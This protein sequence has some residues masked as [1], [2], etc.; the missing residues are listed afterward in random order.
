MARVS[1]YHWQQCTFSPQPYSFELKKNNAY[2]VESANWYTL[3]PECQVPSAPTGDIVCSKVLTLQPGDKL[4]PTW[5]EPSHA[6][7]LYDNAG[8]LTM[9][10]YGLPPAIVSAVIVLMSLCMMR[11]CSTNI[12]DLAV[13]ALLTC[14]FM[15]HNMVLTNMNCR[16]QHLHQHL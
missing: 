10:L 4:I 3:P 8:T 14:I 16:L 2:V 1:S 9:D 5:Y 15:N 6:T 12:H 11:F 13:S 7:S